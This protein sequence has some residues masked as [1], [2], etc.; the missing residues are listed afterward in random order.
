MGWFDEQIKQRAKNDNNA[1]SSAFAD[2]SGVVTGKK[3][4]DGDLDDFIEANLKRG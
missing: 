1:F 4:L 3:V 2:M